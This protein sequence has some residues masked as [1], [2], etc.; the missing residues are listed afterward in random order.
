MHFTVQSYRLECN[1]TIISDQGQ[2]YLRAH[3]CLSNDTTNQHNRVPIQ[4]QPGDVGVDIK[5]LFYAETLQ[6]RQMYLYDTIQFDPF[7]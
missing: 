5:V 2:H 6:K 7:E 1:F 3:V 4:S